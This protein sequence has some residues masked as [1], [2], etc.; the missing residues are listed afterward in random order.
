M[1]IYKN[2]IDKN[3][4]NKIYKT[5]LNVNFPWYYI[6]HQVSTNKKDTSYMRHTFVLNGK[7]NSSAMSLIEPILYKLKAKKVL[8]VRANLCFKRPSYC[9]WHVDKFT[10]NL[11]HKTAIYY[12]NSNNGYTEFKNK[13]IKCEKNKIVIFDADKKHRAIGQTD[14]DARV[15]INFNYEYI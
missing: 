10:N 4:S 2:F 8:N 11:K 13:K 3:Y 15:V 14:K 6:P 7:K 12:V 1:N 9:S 5:L